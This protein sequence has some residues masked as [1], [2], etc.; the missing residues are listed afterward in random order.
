MRAALRLLL[1]GIIRHVALGSRAGV[2]LGGRCPEW[3]CARR[4]AGRA[5]AVQHRSP[6]ERSHRRPRPQDRDP[7]FRRQRQARR[8]RTTSSRSS[9]AFVWPCPRPT[10]PSSARSMRA[11]WSSRPICTPD[12]RSTFRSPRSSSTPAIGDPRGWTCRGPFD[13]SPWRRRS[14]PSCLP[15]AAEFC[16]R[17]VRRRLVRHGHSGPGEPFPRLCADDRLVCAGR[18]HGRRPERAA[19]HITTLTVM[20]FF[21]SLFSVLAASGGLSGL[22][23]RLGRRAKTREHGQLLALIFGFGAFL[24]DYAHALIVGKTLRPLSDR[25]K[26]SREKFAFLVDTTCAPV[27]ALAI[28]STWLAAERG[29]I[30]ETFA[31][32][33]SSGGATAT[34][35]ASLPYCFYPILM[36]IFAALAIFLGHDFGPM[37][38]AEWRAATHGHLSRPDLV[39]PQVLPAAEAEPPGGRK[40]ARN[41]WIPILMLFGLVAVGLWWTGR[42]ELASLSADA[43]SGDGPSRSS[44]P[45]GSTCWNMRKPQRVLLFSVFIASAAAVALGVWSRS[46]TLQQGLSAWVSGLQRM[47]P[48]ALILL[49]SWSFQRICD[50]DHLNTAG[51]LM[52]IGQPRVTVEWVPL[53]AFLAV[54]LTSF[55]VGSSWAALPLALPLFISVTHALLVDLNEASPMHPL[56]L[57]TI[58][59]V[60]GGTV[61]GHHCSPISETTVLSSASTSCSHLDHVFTQLPYA[62]TVASVVALFG[63]VPVAYGHS[64]VVLLPL[65]TI[66]LLAILQFG[67]RPAVR[68]AAE[69]EP[70]PEPETQPP[71]RIRSAGGT[72]SG[73]S[74]ARKPMTAAAGKAAPS[75][76]LDRMTRPNR[77][78]RIGTTTAT[79]G[80]TLALSRIRIFQTCGR[81]LGSRRPSN[82]QIA[83]IR[84]QAPCDGIVR[85]RRRGRRRGL[86][87]IIRHHLTIAVKAT[88]RDGTTRTAA[89][90]LYAQPRPPGRFGRNQR[91]GAAALCRLADRPRRA[92]LVSQRL[93]GRVH[94]VPRRRAPPHHRDHRRPDRGPR[95]DPGRSGRGQ[96]P[97]NARRLRALRRLGRPGRG[98][99]RAVLLQAQ[100]GVGLRLLPRDR[101]QHAGR[102]DALQHPDVRQP[103]RRADGAAACGRVRADRG[104]QGFVGRHPAHDPHD[105]VGPP[106]SARLRLPHRLGRR[107]RCRCSWSAATAAPTPARASC[108]N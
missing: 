17:H 95:A 81:Q 52:E 47:V 56:L 32:L 91:A 89:G 85:S 40:L 72:P 20:L 73:L 19:F 62:V 4:A 60:I 18:R 97:R 77:V 42:E 24:D 65:A 106:Q 87:C 38:R 43:S 96:R 35:L 2:G 66:V 101:T 63:Y 103:D 12:A 23:D 41:A 5:S 108:R 74:E 104:D 80:S 44:P 7:G 107:A 8:C 25:L 90:H 33:G 88:V 61:F 69:G 11:F 67:G 26:I 51:F 55:I 39:D 99:R 102:R 54:G 83:L 37:L 6:V 92:R 93:D 58:G 57:A 3:Q 34:L 30:R 78:I 105:Q 27:T 36:L 86:G 48:A 45:R 16:P 76:R 49:L 84:A 31:S 100:P 68:D 94:A 59:A 50:A 70:T 71:P 1:N 64:P 15:L 79:V 10:T 75:A 21:G 53:V 13:G 22:T 29:T 14:S 28:V 9:R 98:H 46:L 82:R